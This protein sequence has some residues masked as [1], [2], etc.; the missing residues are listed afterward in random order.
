MLRRYL[1]KRDNPWELLLIASFIFF[2]GVALRLQKG[3]FVLI[4]PAGR[5]RVRATTF[6]PSV[7]HTAGVIAIIFS[8]LLVVLYVYARFAI[9]RD[10]E[11]PP[12][13]FLDLP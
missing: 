13:H 2:P 1:L 5:W 8:L 3:P 7:A 11:A 12:P 4:S 9:K 10:E 6:P